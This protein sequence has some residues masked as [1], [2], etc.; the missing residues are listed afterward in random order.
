MN[1]M[2]YDAALKVGLTMDEINASPFELSGGQKRRAAMAGVLAMNPGILVLDEPASGLDPRGRQEMFSI[3]KKLRDS[4]TTIILVSH[5]MD[6]AAVNC[7]RICIIDGG[8]I[9]AV[10][11]PGELFVKEKAGELG[12]QRPRISRFSELLKDE[13]KKIYPGISF[14]SLGFDPQE[15]AAA[16]VSA[17]VRAGAQD[18]Q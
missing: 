5:N 14:K 10:G 18:V 17:V 11:T 8:K 4:G 12:I 3:I 16:V 15:E 13:L 2:A 7:D 1:K 9:R 6:E